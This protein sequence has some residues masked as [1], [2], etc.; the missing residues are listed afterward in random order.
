MSARV[1]FYRSDQVAT[2]KCSHQSAEM[3]QEDGEC[4]D[5]RDELALVK[6]MKLPT[7]C[8]L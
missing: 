6:N 4:I 5:A 2:R 3:F 8:N 1:S 7:S